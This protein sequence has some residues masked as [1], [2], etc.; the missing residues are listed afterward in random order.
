MN[1]AKKVVLIPHWIHETLNRHQLPVSEALNFNALRRIVSANDMAAYVLLNRHAHHVGL[2]EPNE[3]YR[4]IDLGVAF[5]KTIMA[6]H[7]SYLYEVVYPL[8][9]SPSV[10]ND[11]VD[12]LFSADSRT[13]QYEE[14]FNIYDLSTEFQGVVINPGFFTGEAG[15]DQH[16]FNLLEAVVK[17]LYVYAPLHEVASTSV[18]L[19]YL[20]LLSKKRIMV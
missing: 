15:S 20:G 19:R 6:E 14:P 3:Q 1:E 10:K 5:Q 17:A 11:L 4:E 16:V 9:D 8:A 2:G 13:P 7:T 12:R 18:F